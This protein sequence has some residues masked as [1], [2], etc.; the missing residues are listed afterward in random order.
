M[1][2]L[3]IYSVKL[4]YTEIN[5]IKAICGNP[6]VPF[7]MEIRLVYI[8]GNV[9]KDTKKKFSCEVLIAKIPP[10]SAQALDSFSLSADY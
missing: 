6:T 2:D 1:L 8:A 10:S 7:K 5:F 4:K 9:C 3:E